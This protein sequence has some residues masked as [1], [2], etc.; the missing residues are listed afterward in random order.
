MNI[1]I[2]KQKDTPL[3]SRKRVTA[4]LTAEAAT[5]SR[6]TIRN[7]LAKQLKVDP[8][9]VIIKHL[10]PQF[11]DRVVKVIVNVY[12]KRDVLEKF[13]HK[14]LVAKHQEKQEGSAEV[15]EAK[16]AAA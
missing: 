14:K 11:G 7:L 9:L 6:L 16:P 3:L 4:K 15:K 13:E 8:S 5:P 2:L 12:E 1:E 10:Y